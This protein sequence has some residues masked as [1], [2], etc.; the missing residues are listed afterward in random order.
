MPRLFS[1]IAF[2]LAFN[3]AHGA[4]PAGKQVKLLPKIIKKAAPAVPLIMK[5]DTAA[6]A[7]RYF[8]TVKIQALKKQPEF[9]YNDTVESSPS[10]WRRFWNWLKSL[11]KPIK[12]GTNVSKFWV[13]FGYVLKYLL[14]IGGLAGVVFLSLKLAG[15]DMLN[16]F[17]RKPASAN[18]EYSELFEDIHEI[19]FDD[20]IEKAIAQHNYRL[21]VRLLY[22]RSLKHLS[23]ADLIKWQPEKTNNAYIDEL[24]N[25]EQKRFFKTLTL[26]FE[27]V[28]Y[29]EFA[30]NAQAFN[31][32]NTAFTDFKKS[33]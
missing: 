24:S 18:L 11:F 15:I 20:E 6:I 7:V 16:V 27:Y 10:L 22:L 2:L 19:N 9:Q 4:Q 21:A 32:I 13:V 23:D 12:I 26:Q 29:G 33:I 3:M 8:D 17:R 28:W 30:I 14:I 25:S 31:K 5:K 1:I